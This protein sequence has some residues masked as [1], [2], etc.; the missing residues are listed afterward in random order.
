MTIE[1]DKQQIDVIWA[2]LLEL[3]VK[4]ALPV[5]QAIER[6]LK[7]INDDRESNSTPA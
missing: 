4:H 2:G 6:Q 7:K 1:L 5:M 3:P